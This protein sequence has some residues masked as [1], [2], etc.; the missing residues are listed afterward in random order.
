MKKSPAITAIS[1]IM[2]SLIFIVAS[3]GNPLAHGKKKHPNK[4]VEGEITY[5]DHIVPLFK[6]RCAKCHGSKSPVHMEFIKDIERHKK[7][8][9]G[10]RMD[11]YTHLT[12]FIIWPDTASLMK[13]LDDGS[14]AKDGKPGKMYKHLGKNEE[15]R[16]NNLNLFKS[17]VG[18]WTLKDWDNITKEE[19]SKMK[20]A[21]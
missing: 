17:W 15:E 11:T 4:A 12:S 21:Y 10:P 3:S 13:A 5:T 18:N 1:V 8:M 2:V 14:N 19:L 20:L 9:K 16:Q 6:I 7:K